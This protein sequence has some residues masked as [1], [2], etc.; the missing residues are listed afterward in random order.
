M[1]RK[2]ELNVQD[3][4]LPRQ[5]KLPQKLDDGNAETYHFPSTPKDHY[6]QIYFEAL[7]AATNCIKEISD[8]PDF[9]NYVL[10]QE[11]FLKSIKGQPCE[12]EVREVC[13]IYS[14]DVDKYRFERQLP[15]L[16]PIATAL[17]FELTKF[18]IYDLVL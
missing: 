5:K 11:V 2:E 14:G 1:K 6:R 18:T 17:E 7:D 12:N 10:L 16:P 8:Q 9:Q 13:S 4:K 15:L 3:P